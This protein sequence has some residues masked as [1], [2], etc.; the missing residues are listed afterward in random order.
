MPAT[1]TS[2]LVEVESTEDVI[3]EGDET[4]GLQVANVVSGTVT[5]AT[6]TGTGLVTEDETPPDVVIS[7][8]TAN[9]GQPDGLHRRSVRCKR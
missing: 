5:S 2:I 9:E 6:D 1:V 7:D 4:F 8:A 3:Y